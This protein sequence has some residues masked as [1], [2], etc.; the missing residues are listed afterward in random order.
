MSKLYITLLAGGMGK[1]MESTLPKVLHKVKGV[2]MIV[3]VLNQVIALNPYKI[4]IVVGKFYNEI[5]TEIEKNII[6][7]R[8]FY[9]DQLKPL[10]TG[11]AVKCTLD[12]LPSN[13]T[14]II[15]N[16]DNPMISVNTL[17]EIYN[18]HI[19]KKS[20]FSITT[21][22]LKDPSGSGRI[23][24]N[25]KDCLKQ[26]IEEKDCTESQKL[27]KTINCGIYVISSNILKK[28][29][30]LINNNNSQKEYYL[31]D[32]IQIYIDQTGNDVDIHHLS[33]DKFIEIYNVNTKKQLEE[34]ESII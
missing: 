13:I 19:R 11:D 3:R 5:I 16:A 2:A 8:I 28:Y 34:I 4:I 22:N 12:T 17:S 24:F 15:L 33:D 21:I 6:D 30:P 7:D 14:N 10:G 25:D 27:I 18:S 23:M 9:I 31:T 29:I 1:R 26:I 32:L 20:L